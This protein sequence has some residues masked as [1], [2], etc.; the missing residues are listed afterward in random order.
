[1]KTYVLGNGGF[2]RDLFEQIFLRNYSETNFGGFIILNNDKPFVIS[3][4]GSYEFDYPSDSNFILG[5]GNKN[6]RNS[7]IEHFKK[8]YPLSATYFPNVFTQNAY[9]SKIGNLG[10]GNVFCAFSLLNSNAS[11]GNF[12]CFNIYSTI[13]HDCIMG[14]NNILSPYA[15]IMGYCRVGNSNFLGTHSTVTPKVVIGNEN[16]I[17]A[18]ECLFDNLSDRK[19]FSSGVIY[20]KP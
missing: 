3:D 6:W 12:N 10:F 11:I 2:A 9:I 20:N 8:H 17:N 7:F 19:F 5:T 16:T 13:S 14:D 18:G 1:M 4:K 15:G